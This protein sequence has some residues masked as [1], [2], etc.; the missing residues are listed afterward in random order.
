MKKIGNL[1]LLLL[2]SL[3]GGVLAVYVHTNFF[4]Q[5]AIE[6][7]QKVVQ[8]QPANVV[9]T[10]YGPKA[11]PESLDFRHASKKVTPAVVHIKIFGDAGYAS[12]GTTMED[13]MREFFG[14]PQRPQNGGATGERPIGTGS[15]VIVKSDGYIITNNHVVENADRILVVL[16][17]KRE[18][19]ATLIGT[20]PSTDL[21]VVKI[22]AEDNLPTLE[23]GDSDG[24]EVGE[25][26]LAVG[27]PFDLTSTVTA[28]IVSAKARNINILRS[29]TDLSIE[30]FI[31]TDAAVN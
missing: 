27:N 21:A 25:W 6:S 2:A 22:K 8:E 23:F 15:G 12:N 3:L 7:A 20:D 1:F 5:Q 14:E 17:D 18:Y 24:I 9:E 29:A 13:M 10:R 19:E 16:D 28:G 11:I 4:P 31:Q 26:V 30:S